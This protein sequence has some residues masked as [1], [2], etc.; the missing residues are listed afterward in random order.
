M[1]TLQPTLQVADKNAVLAFLEKH[2]EAGGPI[3]ISVERDGP[4][5]HVEVSQP[6][7]ECGDDWPDCD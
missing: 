2:I 7:D 1:N 5:Y 4:T 3:N 6:T